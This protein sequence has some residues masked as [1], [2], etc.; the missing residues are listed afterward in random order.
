MYNYEKLLQRNGITEKQLPS[1]IQKVIEK[2]HNLD[3]E[4]DEETEDA[5]IKA[6]SASL[7]EID[8]ELVEEISDYLDDEAEE[9]LPVEQV[10]FNLLQGFFS[11]NVTKIPLATLK[12][13]GY[14]VPTA[15]KWSE[16][17]G[18]FRLQKNLYENF[19]T[20]KKL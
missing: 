2:L 17:I 5:E 6:I 13:S 11:S 7:R 10:K 3:Y 16:Q 9:D 14:T 18:T 20:L 12:A 8:L 15:S 4:L 1:S 19:A